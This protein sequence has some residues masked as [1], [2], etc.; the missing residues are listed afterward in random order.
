MGIVSTTSY[1]EAKATGKIYLDR[2]F[3][4]NIGDLTRNIPKRCKQCASI[5][6]EKRNGVF[7]SQICKDDY[8]I[9]KDIKYNDK[10]RCSKCGGIVEHIHR[11]GYNGKL[12]RSGMHRKYCD[13]CNKPNRVNNVAEKVEDYFS[14]IYPHNI[15]VKKLNV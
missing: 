3:Y 14:D 12:Y 9:S 4:S 10:H 2:A 13:N 8:T 11:V 5:M 1:S 6:P 15:F 7:C